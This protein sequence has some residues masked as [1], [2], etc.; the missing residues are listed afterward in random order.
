MDIN[1][2]QLLTGLSKDEISFYD[3]EGL[4]SIEK[5][6]NLNK[7]D[8]E[9]LKYVKLL[10]KL[11]I[12]IS[13]IKEFKSKKISLKCLLEEKIKELENDKINIEG[14]EDTVKDILKNIRKK[15]YINVNEYLE[16]LESIDNGEYAEFIYDLDNI[17][18]RSLISQILITITCLT[19]IMWFY[20]DLA[21]KNYNQ[22]G[23]RGSLSILTTIILTLTCKSYLQQKNKKIGGTL[24]YILGG[25]LAI[26]LTFLI[27]IGIDWLQLRIFVPND[28]LMYVFKEPYSYIIFLFEAEVLIMIIAILC[29]IRK[30]NLDEHEWEY[31]L[32]SFMKRNIIKV[33]VINIILLY[34]CITGITVITKEKIIDYNFYNPIGVE[35]TYNDITKIDTGFLGNKKLL[36]GNKGDF[37][38]KIT[39]K[40]KKQIELSDATSDFD[41]TYLELEIFDKIVAEKSNARKIASKENYK[42]CD[43]GKIYL[44]R[45]LRIIEK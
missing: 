17:G 41:D 19:P 34:I 26:I 13:K 20:L 14:K 18:E 1:D 15:K 2:I 28:Y 16:E 10:L 30:V 21:E 9:Q 27:F 39:L 45:F 23:F 35:Y 4:I 37:Y 8:I 31:N 7:E 32:L 5:N 6:L 12:P 36:Y 22:I 3:S 25:I 43:I 42:L 33:V 38:Y 24:G 44:D 40:N 11:D 29:K